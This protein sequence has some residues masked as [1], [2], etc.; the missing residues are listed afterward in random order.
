MASTRNKNTLGNYS[1]EQKQNTLVENYELYPNSQH[2]QAYANEMPAVGIAHG[3]MPREALSKN[4][5]EI[6]SMLFGINSTNLVNPQ[7]EVKPKLKKLPE[8]TFFE[9]PQLIMPAP[10]VIENN[11]RPLPMA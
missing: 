3:H 6:E 2:G 1:L 4:P 10:L 8:R 7:A 5:V 9:R 11:Q